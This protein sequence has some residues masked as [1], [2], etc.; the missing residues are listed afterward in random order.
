MACQEIMTRNKG[1]LCVQ[2]RMGPVGCEQRHQVQEPRAVRFMCA[3]IT[4]TQLAL[5]HAHRYYEV[6]NVLL[7]SSLVLC[8]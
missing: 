6:V 4:F 7:S 8:L 2:M 3:L 1:Q 5:Q